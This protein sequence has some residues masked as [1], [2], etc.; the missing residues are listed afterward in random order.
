MP[1]DLLIQVNQLQLHG[2]LPAPAGGKNLPAIPRWWP[3][4]AQ[5][6]Q[7]FPINTLI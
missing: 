7:F 6:V 4:G 5:R 1:L 2:G 3:I